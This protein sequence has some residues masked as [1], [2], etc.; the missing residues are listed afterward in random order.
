MISLTIVIISVWQLLSLWLA[1]LISYGIGN[2]LR[3]QR[4]LSN[5]LK[6]HGVILPE[7]RT[8]RHHENSIAYGWK[9]SAEI[10]ECLGSE[11]AAPHDQSWQYRLGHLI[12]SHLTQIR[13]IAQW[14]VAKQ[15]AVLPAEL[16]GA[17]IADLK[18]RSCR[19]LILG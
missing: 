12:S 17:L 2:I 10:Q 5:L 13:D 15:T 8:G 16:G 3:A 1:I 18:R 14:R 11:R 4:K 7:V 19:I 6:P 9:S